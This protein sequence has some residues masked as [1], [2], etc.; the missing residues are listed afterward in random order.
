MGGYRKSPYWTTTGVALSGNY[1]YVTDWRSL[2]V[3]DISN[4]ANPRQAGGCAASGS[5]RGV[6]VSGSYAYVAAGEAGLQ[7]DRPLEVG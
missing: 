4:P 5:P 6:A 1:A 7:G 2:R 3:I